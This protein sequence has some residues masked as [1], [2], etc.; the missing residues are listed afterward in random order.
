MVEVNK[1]ANN[2]RWQLIK[3]RKEMYKDKLINKNQN[4]HKQ[5][6]INGA[7]KYR[8]QRATDLH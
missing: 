2:Q 5:L 6:N 1:E 7:A 4:I 3:D 8:V